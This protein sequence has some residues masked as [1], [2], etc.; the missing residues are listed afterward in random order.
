MTLVN[1]GF[2][3]EYRFMIKDYQYLLSIKDVEA[4]RYGS[5]SQ[6]RDVAMDCTGDEKILNLLLKLQEFVHK[7]K[8]ET[9]QQMRA[10]I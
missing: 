5:F 7:K 8:L 1:N 2:V 6:N 4:V 9:I 3:S 10:T